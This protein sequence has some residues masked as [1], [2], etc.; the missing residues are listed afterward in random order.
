LTA[1]SGAVSRGLAAGMRFR[2]EARVNMSTASSRMQILHGRR[3]ISD[4]HLPLKPQVPER[5]NRN[6]SAVNIQNAAVVRKFARRRESAAKRL[7]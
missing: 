4:F 3:G 5:P 6:N 1:Y 7:E 2:A